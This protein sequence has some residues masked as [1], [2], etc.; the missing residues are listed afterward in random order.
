MKKKNKV[1]CMMEKK[2]IFLL[3]MGIFILASFLRIYPAVLNRDAN[4]DHFEV[5]EIIAYEGRIPDKSELN[6]LQCYQPKLYHYTVAKLVN[7]FSVS[8]GPHLKIISQLIST[9][10]GIITLVFVYFFLKQ[11]PIRESTRLITFSLTAFNPALIGINIQG[12]NDSFVI[13]FST[14]ALYF[15][16]SFFLKGSLNSFV[17]MTFSAILATLSKGSGLI[18]FLGIVSVFLIKI[19][20]TFGSWAL[21]KKY[22]IFLCAFLFISIPII[23]IFSQYDE[24]YRMYGSPIVINKEKSPLPYFFEKTYVGGKTGTVSLFNGYFTF[25]FFDLIRTP[26][27]DRKSPTGTYSSSKSSLW[28]QLYARSNFIQYEGYPKDWFTKYTNHIY[29]LGKIIYVIALIPLV[30]FLFGIFLDTKKNICGLFK[31]KFS[32]FKAEHTWLFSLFFWAFILF[33]IKFTIEYREF[34]S[35]KPIYIYPAL[36]TFV[37]MFSLGLTFVTER[38]SKPYVRKSIFFALFLLIVLYIIDIAYLIQKL[39]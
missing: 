5:I 7:L 12:T 15:L 35:M 30:I 21:F 38:L 8:T 33:I 26:F 28:T 31:N 27:L 32:Y 11:L 3:F 18:I 10:A 37:Y 19:L 24:Y 16:Y 34:S 36:L 22:I 20:S 29:R 23:S 13:L 9:V 6:C 4:D 14:A 2:R 39:S 25:Q 17:F 1:P